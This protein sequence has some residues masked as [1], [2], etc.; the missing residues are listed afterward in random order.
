LINDQRGNG[1]PR[2]FA[3]RIDIGSVEAIGDLVLN[4]SN[5]APIVFGTALGPA[6]LNAVANVAGTFTYTP[7]AGTVLE[8]GAAQPLTVLFTP[9]D[10]NAFQPTS[11]TVFIDV[12][13]AEP[14]INWSD[15]Q[16][17]T[18]GTPLSTTQLN[19]KVNGNVP[20]TF[21]YTPPA[22]TILEVGENRVLSVLFVPNDTVHYKNATA[23]VLLD[24]I[25]VQ[26]VITWGNPADI[27]YGTRLSET[28]LNAKANV[29]GSF[30]YVPPAG[31]LMNAGL[32]Q[33]LTVTFNV[34]RT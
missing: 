32:N 5:P 1:F 10:L 3:D 18:F 15:P 13:K 33:T 16:P 4:W 12:E 20:G 24:V 22:G 34:A 11:A 30:S 28:Q 17:I 8:P 21:T 9:D 19:A 26:P 7:T 14:V 6:Q 25:A 23:S 29:P 2:I 27:V 31:V